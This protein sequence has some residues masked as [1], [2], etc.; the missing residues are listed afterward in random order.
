MRHV[1]RGVLFIF[2]ALSMPPRRTSPCSGTPT[3][4]SR[5]DAS[6]PPGRRVVV[7]TGY[8]TSDG[9]SFFM[10]NGRAVWNEAWLF[11]A[12]DNRVLRHVYE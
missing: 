10:N 11:D 2:G 5:C 4:A 7:Y 12:S 6:I 1:L 9:V 3:A 8:G